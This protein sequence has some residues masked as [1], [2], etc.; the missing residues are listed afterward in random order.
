MLLKKLR[1]IYSLIKKIIIIFLINI[2]VLEFLSLILIKVK[3]IPGGLTPMVAFIA[4]ENFAVKRK[5]NTKFKFS[6]K[7]WD[8]TVYYNNQGI[9]SSYDIK[10]K[11]E[12]IRII[13]L[14]DS[15]TE[16]YQLSDN[17]DLSSMIQKTI[18]NEKYEVINFGFS[19]TGISEHINLYEIKIKKLNPDYLIYFPDTTDISD[20][21][22][23]RNRLNQHMYMIKNGLPGRIEPNKEFWDRYNSKYNKFKR[24]YIY[25]VKKYS[26]FYKLYWTFWESLYVKRQSLDK[27]KRKQTT[28]DSKKYKEQKI[29]YEY[30]A[31]KFKE[32]I[33]RSTTKFYVIKTLKSNEIEHFKT[34]DSKLFDDKVNFFKKVWGSEN[35]YNPMNEA[36]AYLKSKGK[37]KFPYFSFSCDAHYDIEGALFYSKFISEK[38]FK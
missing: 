34:N 23:S 32:K 2:V 21:H 1:K 17:K 8:S 37:Y 15:M 38:I 11:K 7:C 25:Y 28:V 6:S 22:Y 30:L 19:S 26:N 3:F 12:K 4:D 13:L 5:K 24:E 16:N 33:D 20:N 27:Q 18:G 10:E 29:I 36:V 31:E 14:G 9:R 35:Y